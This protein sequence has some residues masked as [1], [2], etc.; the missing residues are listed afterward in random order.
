MGFGSGV[1]LHSTRAYNVRVSALSE[2]PKDT[3]SKDEGRKGD[4][5]SQEWEQEHAHEKV[6]VMS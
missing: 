2:R 3:C 5:R 6:F 1:V 4:V